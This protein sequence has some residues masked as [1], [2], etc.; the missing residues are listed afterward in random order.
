MEYNLTKNSLN[1]ISLFNL[2]SSMNNF[3]C[4]Q[5]FLASLFF[6]CFVYVAR[7]YSLR[8]HIFTF[9]KQCKQR[10]HN[11]IPFHITLPL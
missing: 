11:I 4:Q 9:T 5:A 2:Y 1:A 8:I 3:N 7:F 10:P 6:I